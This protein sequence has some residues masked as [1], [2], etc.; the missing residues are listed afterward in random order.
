MNLLFF[1]KPKNYVTYLTLDSTLRQG[2][3]KMRN[4]GYTEIPVIDKDG[5]YAGTVRQG[6]FLWKILDNGYTD[7][8]EAENETIRAIV[9][10]RILPVHIDTAI[11]ELLTKALDQNFVPVIDDLDSFIGIIT[12]RDII[13]YFIEKNGSTTIT[14]ANFPASVQSA[15]ASCNR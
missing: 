11:D 12:R 13:K 2:L 9:S 10:R 5:L 14:A 4:S 15:K 8:R 1:L 6:D 3:E 7:I